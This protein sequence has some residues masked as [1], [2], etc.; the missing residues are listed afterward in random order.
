V[1]GIE[2][3]DQRWNNLKKNCLENPGDAA[4]YRVL[5]KSNLDDISRLLRYGHMLCA[6]GAARDAA[7][8]LKL[9]HSQAKRRA[10]DRKCLLGLAARVALLDYPPAAMGLLEKILEPGIGSRPK[11][12]S[13]FVDL[14]LKCSKY[15]SS[16][17]SVLRTLSFVGKISFSIQQ[18]L[19][20][21]AMLAKFKNEKSIEF[22]HQ[23]LKQMSRKPSSSDETLKTLARIFL[24]SVYSCKGAVKLPNYVRAVDLPVVRDAYAAGFESL[25]LFTMGRYEEAVAKG[26]NVSSDLGVLFNGVRLYP[27]RARSEAIVR[28]E[29][30]DSSLPDR[31]EG[32]NNI[33]LVVSC[34]PVFLEMFGAAYVNQLVPPASASFEITIFV[35]GKPRV[36]HLETIRRASHIPIDFKINEAPVTDKAFYTLR[37]F[38]DLPG[39]L[40]NKDLVIA[41]DIDAAVDLGDPEFV[42][43]LSLSAGGWRD[44]GSDLPWLRHSA[45]FVYFSNTRLGNWG[46]RCLS[47]LAAGL[48][49]ARAEAGNWYCD[50]ICLS[51]V[52]DLVPTLERSEFRLLCDTELSRHFKPYDGLSFD[53]TKRLARKLTSM[54]SNGVVRPN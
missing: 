37:R 6:L 44:T 50:Q 23:L 3:R 41:T 8:I 48:Y 2:I 1:G 30:I 36:E 21:T 16:Y 45:G 9:C 46:A 4:S 42:R 22:S 33:G 25:H 34:D 40:Q 7:A 29:G 17:P 20:L 32:V 5:V 31:L 38:L 52:W 54:N 19:M 14:L 26:T 35:D 43:Q 12:H 28:G 51:V 13:C 27:S 18:M 24:W 47:R 11:D 10:I 15:K 49:D 53:P 39:I